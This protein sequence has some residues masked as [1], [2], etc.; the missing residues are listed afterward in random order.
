MVSVRLNA[1]AYLC[2]ILFLCTG[3]IAARQ[4]FS[5][6]QYGGWGLKSHAKLVPP[7]SDQRQRLDSLLLKIRGGEDDSTYPDDR[8][9]GRYDGYGDY[10]EEY[11]DDR[12]G[13]RNSYDDYYD[14]QGRSAAPSGPNPLSS[15]MSKFKHGD[16]RIGF[17]LL[18]LGVVFTAM[19]V[20]LFFNKA[21]M[22]LG[23]LMMIAGIPTTIGP[24]RAAGYFLKPEKTRATACLCAGIFLV[25]VGW[26]I[27]GI[28]LEVF[29]IMN[30]FGNMFPVVWAI[31]KNMPI[32]SSLLNSGGGGSGANRRQSQSY[33]DYDYER[34]PYGDDD[35]D[36]YN[37]DDRRGYGDY[38]DDDPYY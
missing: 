7:S 11:T 25:F 5:G 36:P 29:G 37:T 38:R 8:D 26:P 18:G 10:P 28:V 33:R 6:I 35:R 13:G 23:N 12:R 22:R 1:L 27:V 20:S 24:S 17:A 15:A 31:V 16:K 32:V 14:G 19:G 9:N 3:G 2:Q 21:L 34:D 4:A 30:I